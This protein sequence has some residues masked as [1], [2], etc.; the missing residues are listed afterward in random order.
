MKQF[1]SV[2]E[3]LAGMISNLSR[4]YFALG[5]TTPETIGPKYCEG[6]EWAGKISWFVNKIRNS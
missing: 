6:N 3:G 4:N 1:N 2:D 5:L